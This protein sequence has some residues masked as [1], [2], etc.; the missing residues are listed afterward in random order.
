[1]I[2]SFN[3]LMSRIP[4]FNVNQLHTDWRWR[5][6]AD[7]YEKNYPAPEGAVRK[8]PKKIHQIWLGSP[9]P[10]QYKKWGESWQKFHPDYEYKLWTEDDLPLL[11]V[12]LKAYH[13]LTNYGPKSDFMRY[14]ILDKFGGIYMDTD[15]ECLKSFE[16]LAYLDF[17]I[18]VG[19]PSKVEL[20]PGLIGC[21]P[22]HP[23]IH[24]VAESIRATT[25]E[26]VRRKGTLGATSSYFFTEVFFDVI[27]EYQAGVL[28]LPPDYLY[29]FPNHKGHHYESGKDYIKECSYAIHYWEISWAKYTKDRDWIRGD[30]FV[31]VADFVYAPKVFA[32]DDYAKYPNTFIPGRLRSVTFVY[33]NIMYLAKLLSII[34]HLPNKYVVIA[35]NGDQHVEDGVIGTYDNGQKIKEEPYVMSD[36][37][38]MLYC[39]NIDVVHPRIASIPLGV[40]NAMWQKKTD[41]M[42]LMLASVRKGILRD[43][44]L[45]INH[46]CRTNSQERNVVYSLLEGKAWVTAVR[47]KN[48][49]NM[50]EYFDNVVSHKFVAAPWGNGFDTHRMWEALYMG[51]IPI[52]R[53]CVFTSFYEDLPVCLID[54][55][56]EVTEEF[57][58][59]EWIRL[60]QMKWDKYKLDFEYWR[61]KVRN[62]V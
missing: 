21:I 30:K 15:F 60:K 14:N 28:A 50:E 1:M 23:I 34:Q 46:D 8:I 54:S 13:A 25:A 18:G 19:Y 7:L 38:L 4:E 2:E 41:K 31:G 5:L 10:E 45:Y 37:I 35:H 6:L 43:K 42:A 44:L 39:Q 3:I 12:N 32:S 49:N 58:N 27:R 22:G 17:Y 56:E 52:V 9:I 40:E 59:L 61:N 26:D 33:T 36:N 16:P 53:R 11:D 48:R 47:G 57:L 29:P 62:I 24:K 20:Y 55:W 51:S